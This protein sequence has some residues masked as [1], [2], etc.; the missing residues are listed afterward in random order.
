MWKTIIGRCVYRSG[1][2]LEIGQNWFYRWLQFDKQALQSVINRRKPE[3]PAMYYIKA[4]AAMARA[5]PANTLLLGLGGGSVAHYLQGC[6]NKAQLTVIEYDS[7]VIQAAYDWFM[8]SQINN[9]QI[10]Q[11][12]AFH[13][14]EKTD[15][16]Y[17]HIMVDLFAN[18]AFPK[19]CMQTSFFQNCKNRLTA[20]G[21]LAVNMAN[22]KQHLELLQHIRRQFAHQTLVIPIKHSA[23]IVVIAGQEK[24]ILTA[25]ESL[26]QSL[27]IK[28]IEWHE[29]WGYI[30]H[31]RS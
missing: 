31:P 7:A 26:R 8:I 1:Q 9:L 19:H 20:D 24:N 27:K 5:K 11:E 16:C 21:F 4:L 12:D 28:N 22:P 25:T 10:I 14:L 3:K 30:V 29:T 15:T 17:Q 6:L 2:D 18:N 13:Y 23:N